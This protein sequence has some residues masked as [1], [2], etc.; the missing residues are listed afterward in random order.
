MGPGAAEPFVS[1]FKGFWEMFTLFVPMNFEKKQ[2]D[3]SNPKFASGDSSAAIW[4]AYKNYKKSHGML[5]W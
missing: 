1:I 2:K 4:Q 5:S 3:E